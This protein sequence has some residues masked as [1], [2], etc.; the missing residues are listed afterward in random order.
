MLFETQIL[1]LNL[2]AHFAKCCLRLKSSTWISNHIFQ[3]V[4]W[5]SKSSTWISKHILQNVVWDSH[6]VFESQST[7]CKILGTFMVAQ[8]RPKSWHNLGLKSIAQI[9]WCK[10]QDLGPN[11]DLSDLCSWASRAPNAQV[12]KSRFD[13]NLKDFGWVWFRVQGLI[14]AHIWDPFGQILAYRERPYCLRPHILYLNLKAHF[15]KMFCETHIQ[16]L[17]LKADFAKYCLR[18][19]SHIW[20]SKQI[21]AKCCLRLTSSTWISKYVFAKC[22]LRLKSSIWISKQILQNVG[23]DSNPVFESQSTFLRNVVWDSYPRIWISKNILQNVVWDSNPIFESQRTFCKMLFETQIPYLNLKAHFAKCCLRLKSC[24]WISKHIFAK[25]CLRLKSSTWISKHILKNVVWGSSHIWIS[26]N[27]LQ[28]AVWD[29]HWVFETQSTF[30]KM[31]FET[32]IEYLNLKAYFAKCCLRL[33]SSV[34][35]SKHISKNVVWD[36]NPVFWI[37]KHIMQ[38]VAWDSNPV[39]EHS[40]KCCLRDSDQVFEFQIS[41]WKMLSGFQIPDLSFRSCFENV[42]WDQF[43]I[44]AWKSYHLTPWLQAFDSQI[45]FQNHGIWLSDPLK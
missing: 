22:F 35:I 36:S 42:V 16:Y 32:H 3:N 13:S 5:G 28:N 9:W 4:V 15:F 23:W 31:L 14:W 45:R 30:C 29:S 19:T 37:S 25:C 20:I 7:F 39:L 17:N 41:F 43:S 12:L 11:R 27:I 38:N 10:C 18:L 2:K 24:I 33:K 21:F 1:Y 8:I 40:L 34:W 6:P 26:K 44:S